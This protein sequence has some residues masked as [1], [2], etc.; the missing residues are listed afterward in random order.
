[1]NFYTRNFFPR[2]MESSLSSAEAMA[3]RRSL[4]STV[5]GQTL[6]IGI[7]E[8]L[9]LLLARDNQQSDPVCEQ[10]QYA[11]ARHPIEPHH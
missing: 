11:A 4:L 1:M 5:Q 9:S 8:A 2:L 10:K 3:L 7:T 6:E